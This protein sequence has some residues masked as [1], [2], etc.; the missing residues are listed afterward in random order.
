MASSSG[1]DKQ[2]IQKKDHQLYGRDQLKF[3]Y[4]CTLNFHK[5]MNKAS[6][7]KLKAKVT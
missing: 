5:K 3:D 1:P 2:G 6:T 7:E 4:M